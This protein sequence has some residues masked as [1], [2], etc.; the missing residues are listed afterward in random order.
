MEDQQMMRIGI[1]G[2]GGISMVHAQVIHGMKDACLAACADILPQRA[3][4][5]ADQFGCAAY[6]DYE[7]MMDKEHLDA[8]HICTPHYL[9]PEMVKKAADRGLAAFTEKPPAI[10]TA[11]W[12]TVLQA[13]EKA[14]VGICFQNRYNPGV[15]RCMDFIKNGT[16]GKLLGIRAFVTWNRPAPYYT[17]TDW[18]GKWATEGG[19]ALINQAVH[20]LDLMLQFL[21]KPDQVRSSMSNHHLSGVTEVEDTAEI[22]MQRDDTPALLYASTAYSQDAPVMIELHFEQA[23]VRLEGDDMEIRRNGEKHVILNQTDEALGR[24]Y[25]GAGHKKCIEDFYRCVKTGETFKNAPQNCRVTM[26]A[27]LEIYRQARPGLQ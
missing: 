5:M 14:P 25:W 2:C 19:G 17:G 21:G 13:A 27:L 23:A 9:H 6:T 26:D 12:Q 1:V 7:E 3:Q 15:L 16:Y 8:V 10:D 4:R 18:K 20:T 22:W 11:G 24:S